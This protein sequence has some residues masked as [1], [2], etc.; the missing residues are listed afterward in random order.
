M[1]A[2]NVAMLPSLYLEGCI[3][4]MR[5]EIEE[6]PILHACEGP[7]QSSPQNR[8]PQQALIDPGTNDR[9]NKIASARPA[10]SGAD[11]ACAGQRLARCPHRRRD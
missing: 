4:A 8:L 2:E 10:N 1:H 3:R 6:R 9:P 11:I 5:C 7:D